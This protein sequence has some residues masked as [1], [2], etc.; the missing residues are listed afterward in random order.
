M[1]PSRQAKRAGLKNLKQ[2]QEL[3]GQSGQI[4]TNWCR[5][6]PKLFKVVLA[7]CVALTNNKAQ[8]GKEREYE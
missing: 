2:V 5:D 1:S 7:G 6:E 4:L 3:T 8:Q